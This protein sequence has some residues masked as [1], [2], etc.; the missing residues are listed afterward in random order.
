MIKYLIYLALVAAGCYF[1]YPYIASSVEEWRGNEDVK[2]TAMGTEATM[3]NKAAPDK[4]VSEEGIFMLIEQSVDTW[5]FYHLENW[6][7]Y[8]PIT[9]STNYN[10]ADDTY[11]HNIRYRAMN[12]NGGIETH[13]KEFK[14]A[15]DAVAFQERRPFEDVFKIESLSPANATEK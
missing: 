5:F 7:S 6:N 12:K 9:R 3:A 15:F 14:V 10:K 8:Q 13:S 2:K 11:R 1:A 4:E